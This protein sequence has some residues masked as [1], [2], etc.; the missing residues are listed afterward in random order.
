M[1]GTCDSVGVGG[2]WLG[3]CYGPFTKKVRPC[4]AMMLVLLVLVLLLLLLLLLLLVLLLLLLLLLLPLPLA[5]LLLTPRSSAT[6]PSTC[7]R[8]SSCCPMAR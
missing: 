4:P 1:G 3:G 7:Y 8:R 6:A 5:L 2:C